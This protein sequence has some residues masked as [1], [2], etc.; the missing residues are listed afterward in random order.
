[1]NPKLP[2]ILLVI[3]L[4]FNAFFLIGGFAQAR[5]QIDRPRTFRAR[6][7]A[8]AK[9]LDL[10]PQQYENFTRIRDEF[11]QILRQ[12]TEKR[13]E[14]FAELVK[15]HP[16]RKVVDQFRSGGSVKKL[17]LQVLDHIQSF[18]G[19]LRPEQR[20]KLV[21]LVRKQAGPNHPS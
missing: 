18:F 9:Q 3:S 17:R 7:E 8:I 10:D 20:Q 21:E 13:Q 4:A 15:D 12:L 11:E 5:K 14:F 2:W 6:T 16:D 19:I 1:M